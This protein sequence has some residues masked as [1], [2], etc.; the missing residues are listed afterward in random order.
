MVVAPIFSNQRWLT[1]LVT[2]QVVLLMAG[3]SWLARRLLRPI[4]KPQPSA[5]Q[6]GSWTD[7]ATISL[8]S[9]TGEVSI[10]MHNGH[11][12]AGQLAVDV[13]LK[14]VIMDIA[15]LSPLQAV[16][17][18]EL[19]RRYRKPSSLGEVLHRVRPGD[20]GTYR[21]ADLPVVWQGA[22]V[23]S[24]LEERTACFEPKHKLDLGE[25]QHIADIA[26]GLDGRRD[27]Q[28]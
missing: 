11:F 3:I 18:A 17:V 27:S 20:M 14:A 5:V 9:R 24:L 6:S 28:G 13:L 8:D 23:M 15:R 10:R 25:L 21:W 22:I 2:A 4:P 26:D 7:D 12:I 16:Q 19:Y 1:P